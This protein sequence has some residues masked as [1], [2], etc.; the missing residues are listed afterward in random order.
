MRDGGQGR[1]RVRESTLEIK[2]HR[3]QKAWIWWKLGR[4]IDRTDGRNDSSNFIL[5]AYRLLLLCLAMTFLA[6]FGYIFLFTYMAAVLHVSQFNF[7]FRLF[8]FSD[9]PLQ[10]QPD[11]YS[12]FIIQAASMGLLFEILSNVCQS[13]HQSVKGRRVVGAT[14]IAPRYSFVFQFSV[15]AWLGLAT[16]IGCS[17]FQLQ[18]PPHLH[19]RPVGLCLGCLRSLSIGIGNCSRMF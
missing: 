15:S 18:Q 5:C 19:R 11:R 17:L 13:M 7:I 16:P 1:Y 10:R 6:Y 8:T 3:K 4:K 9:Q 12:A 2:W 14:R